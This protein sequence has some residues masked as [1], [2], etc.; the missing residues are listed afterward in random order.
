MNLNEKKLCIEGNN[1]SINALQS[2]YKKLGI[3]KDSF[4]EICNIPIYLRNI[5]K[6]I[7]GKY[8]W[9]KDCITVSNYALK[10][11]LNEL[12][13]TEE[14]FENKYLNYIFSIS[15][16]LTHERLHAS[17]RISV[18]KSAITRYDFD[19]YPEENSPKHLVTCDIYNPTETELD[20]EIDI[21]KRIEQQGI[22]EESITEALALMITFN[23]IP[24]FANY[25]I[26][27]L[28]DRTI[29]KCG[30]EFVKAGAK[31]VKKMGT[32]MII[33]FI[34]TRITDNQEDI[35]ANY[36]GEVYSD[37]LST[38]EQIDSTPE[39]N[40]IAHMSLS[41]KIDNILEKSNVTS[42]SKKTSK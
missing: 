33:N 40:E 42:S 25:T 17:R 36:F 20:E 21:E 28:A 9:D 24:K 35:F 22:L 39:T 13:S 19:L 37:L 14:N 30:N 27:E 18:P 29:K 1:H 2:F 15:Q 34:S 31:I 3:E 32:D 23:G 11:I 41:D 4:K 12:E 26:D 16:T 10:D 38:V 7:I 6:E 8:E 5:P